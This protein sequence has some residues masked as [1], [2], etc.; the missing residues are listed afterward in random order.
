M[1]WPGGSWESTL[2]IIATIV[3]VYL[4]VIWLSLLVWTYL[5]IRSRAIFPV[6]QAAAVGLV[7]LFNFPGFF[8]YL[9]L[10]PHETL[11]EAYDRSLDEEALRAE[12]SM[13]LTCPQ[14][15]AAAAEDYIVC[16]HCSQRLQE[17][18]ASCS[19]PVVATWQSCPYCGTARRA[20]QSAPARRTRVFPREDAGERDAFSA[21]IGELGRDAAGANDA[22]IDGA[23]P[24]TEP[25]SRPRR[26]GR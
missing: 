14:C 13:K 5:D 3:A 1:D 16:P 15:G 19:K 6:A 12:L 9:M 23:P 11:A 4:V 8:V 21:I 22:A 26:R 18:C 10:R 7:F 20:A 24:A 25:L 17:P 2:A